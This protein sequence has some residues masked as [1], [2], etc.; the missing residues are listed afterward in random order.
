MANTIYSDINQFNPTERPV[1]TDV[2]AINQSLVNLLSVRR[3][4]R[5]FNPE[6]GVDF[7]ERLFELID[8]ITAFEIFQIISQRVELFEQRVELDYTRSEVTADP[9]NNRYKI[10]LVYKLKGQP[11]VGDLEFRGVVTG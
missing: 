9:D 11:E 2:A 7:E 3:Y 5:L 6:V 10:F 1:L 4:E 8:D